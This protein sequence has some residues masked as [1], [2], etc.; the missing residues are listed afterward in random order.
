MNTL[1]E[2]I[3][4]LRENHS[5]TQDQLAEYLGMTVVN[6]SNYERNVR[7]PKIDSLIAI[8]NKYH[9]SLD[10]LLTGEESKYHQISDQQVEAKIAESKDDWKHQA[11]AHNTNET[12]GLDANDKI[13]DDVISDLVQTPAFKEQVRK[14]LSGKFDKDIL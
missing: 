5:E 8:A 12:V 7:T 3:K 10:Y 6:V 13:I 1:G 14:L 11:A 4:E 9:V 2:R